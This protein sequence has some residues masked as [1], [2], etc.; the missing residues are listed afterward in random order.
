ME[1]HSCIKGKE[2]HDLTLIQVMGNAGR[3]CRRMRSFG[4][5][6]LLCRSREDGRLCLKVPSVKALWKALVLKLLRRKL[7]SSFHQLLQEE[8]YF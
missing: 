2:A 5:Q 1:V 7:T 4:V 3:R 6:A 8:A